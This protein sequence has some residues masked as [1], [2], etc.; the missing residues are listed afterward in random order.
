M[1]TNEKELFL[2]NVRDKKDILFGK[3]S[4][5]ITREK[6]MESW[7]SIVQVLRHHNVR[8]AFEK[9]ASY[10][11]DSVWPNMKRYTLEK[12][13]RKKRTGEAGGTMAKF[14]KVD[15]LVL[16]I[17]GE[18]SPQV[19]GLD[20]TETWMKENVVPSMD[21]SFQCD[22]TP[23]EPTT[24]VTC[25]GTSVSKTGK[26]KATDDFTEIYRSKKLE[27]LDLEIENLRLRNTVLRQ[28]LQR[29]SDQHF[30]EEDGLLY[31]RLE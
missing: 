8:L 1:N 5:S 22:S 26:R 19:C 13:D 11:R 31:A 21:S 14:T 18:S 7:R 15:E 2:I 30:I 23:A 20:V 24:I 29:R 16:D 28:Q 3:F 6:K 17:V 9:E 10:F 27:K 25:P 12:R 4:D